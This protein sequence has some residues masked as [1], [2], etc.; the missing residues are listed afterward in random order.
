MFT[1]TDQHTSSGNNALFNQG[2][3]ESFIQ[4]KLKV[5]QP[6]DKY[7]VEADKAADSIV[8]NSKA[9]PNSFIAPSQTVQKQSEE[10]IQKQENE[11]EIQQKPVVDKIT[12]GVQLKENS[13]LQKNQ[14][15]EVQQKEE[16]VQEKEENNVQKQSSGAGDTS[17]IE[18][19]LSNSKGGG[20]P[21][22][23]GTRSEMESGFGADFSDVRVHNDSNAVQMNQELGSQAFT[24]G[25]DIYFNEG[26]YDPSS[27][28]GKHLLAHELTHTVQQGAS[29]SSDT[30]QKKENKTA[31]HDPGRPASPL[32]ISQRFALNDAWAKYLDEL[33]AK[34]ERIF[35]VDVKI[36]KRYS[37]TIKVTKKTSTVTGKKAKYE[38][39]KKGF[40]RYLNVSGWNFMDPLRNSGVE[41]ILVL[42]NFGDNQI[43][44]GFL[45]VKMKGAPLIADAMGFMKGL[46]S[47]LE[48]MKMHG[49]AKISVNAD[50]LK[51]KF[52]KGKLDFQVNALSTTIAGYIQAGGGIGIVNDGFTINFM[53][54]VDVS[55]VASGE[56][57][58]K[59]KQDG[60]LDG[61][62]EIDAN[63]ANVNA[64]M[65]V[66]YIKGEVTIQGSGRIQSEKFSGELNF[67]VTDE[68]K[69]KQ[70]MHA[71]LGVQTL[72]GDKKKAKTPVKP[73]KKKPK[74]PKN[75]V[76]VGWGTVEATITPWLQGKATVGLD[77]K[78]Q[79]TIVGSITVPNEVKLMEQK[80]KKQTLFDVEIKA[81]YG[82]PLVGQVFLFAGV[83]MFI[84]A[85]FGPLVLKNVG[86]TGTYSTDPA[87]LQN[88]SI[89]GTLNINA[90]ALLGLKIEA[91]VGVTLLGHDVKAGI[92]ATAAAGIQAYAEATPTFE[93]KEKKNPKG[94]KVGETRLKGN[95][96]AAAQLFLQLGGSLFY[97]LDSPWWSPAPDGRTDHP[98][99][100]VQYPLDQ[101]GIGADVDWLVGSEK[102]PELKFK[103]VKFDPGKFTADMMA[104]PPKKKQGESQAK[105]K[106]KF[107]DKTGGGKKQKDPKLDKSGKAQPKGKKRDP[108]KLSDDKKYLQGL[109]ELS[110]LE[111]ANPKP[112]I[113]VVKTKMQQ[114]KQKY[115]LETVNIKKQKDGEVSIYVKHKKQNNGKRLLNIKMMSSAERMKLLTAAMNDLRK[116]ETKIADKKG[117]IV[118]AKAKEM[119][120]AWKKAHPVI[121]SAKVVDGK[122]TWDYEIN[123]GEKKGIE[124][125]KKKS[126]KGFKHEKV[127]DNFKLKNGE[128]HKLY[129]K[130][131]GK[132]GYDLI[133]ESTPVVYERFI[134][135]FSL[136]ADATQEQKD[137]KNKAVELAKKIDLELDRLEKS[138]GLG[139]TEQTGKDN[140]KLVQEFDKWTDELA[141]LTEQLMNAVYG[142]ETPKNQK[143]FGPKYNGAFGSS[144]SINYLSSKTT[145]KDST[146]IKYDKHGVLDLRR[147][148]SGKRPYY[149]RGHLLNADL[150][151]P[152]EWKNLTPLTY[153]ANSNHKEKIEKELTKHLKHGKPKKKNK[154]RVFKY[155]VLAQYGRAVN[156]ALKDKV[157]KS[158]DHSDEEK[159]KINSI[160]DAEAHVPRHLEIKAVELKEKDGKWVDDKPLFDNRIV[161]DIDQSSPAA[162]NIGD[163]PLTVIMKLK[164]V[165][166]AF[167]KKWM[168]PEAVDAIIKVRDHNPEKIWKDHLE[169]QQAAL[170]EVS[171]NSNVD[172]TKMRKDR[173]AKHIDLTPD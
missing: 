159:T 18:N 31:K 9:S 101:M 51:N 127:K 74:T 39:H 23:T 137:L 43:T 150:H 52:E 169:L 120:V 170:K 98:L 82:I 28:S 87:V 34:G 149:L 37:G 83:G 75:Q 48:K 71:A 100:E 117:T 132:G 46:N 116:R 20:S 70:M 33:Y 32:D 163:K 17:G 167:L 126:G 19:S 115:G 166:A 140:D 84:N 123:T 92:S 50:G 102:P 61:S 160:V 64:K 45:S 60:N 146:G 106:G 161:N 21:L 22:D 63:I 121:E 35:E 41:P 112:S 79:V 171:E 135:K 11:Q 94:G 138:N 124:K 95:F 96:E 88:F 122:T 119:I 103:P 57:N 3:N 2:K 173:L 164:K 141:D 99:G 114:V 85:G 26:K 157:E 13:I 59:R 58:I 56:L 134:N 78:G 128:K 47:N 42:N 118:E 129:L 30:V 15:E 107:N 72:E 4:P 44:T 133:M 29:P 130:P 93:Y 86:F 152:N 66:E 55:G 68:A 155:I 131:N 36:G 105:P 80:G 12:P 108:K 154:K 144:V 91:G 5:G 25:S 151:G 142:G 172:G 139:N 162:Y 97:E 6:G 153:T 8:A 7:E 65:K 81:G 76:L 147:G 158:L 67:L 40:A 49:I 136:P 27:D 69:S 77:H 62:V 16:E 109:G 90:F 168:D 145:G 14:E 38:L 53:G 54:K 24:N 165:T 111:K 143:K 113:G 73:N 89:T 156:T 110:K 10:D 1:K 125:G 104:D 148:D